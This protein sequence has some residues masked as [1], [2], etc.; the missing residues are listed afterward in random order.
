MGLGSGLGAFG[1]SLQGSFTNT[2]AAYNALQDAKYSQEQRKRETELQKSISALGNPDDPS[3]IDVSG[4]QGAIPL[5]DIAGIDP[6][7][8]KAG[9]WVDAPMP[10]ATAAPAAVLVPATAP[11]STVAPASALPTAPMATVPMATAPMATAPVPAAGQ[12]QSPQ[13]SRYFVYEGD[14]GALMAAANP[15]RL[16]P[17]A[18]TQ[19]VV[20]KLMTSGLP[21]YQALG[22]QMQQN[23]RQQ[24]AHDLSMASERLGQGVARAYMTAMTTGDIS[25]AMD[26]LS[27]VFNTESDVTGQNTVRYE[28]VADKPGMF[29]PT[30]YNA[31]GNLVYTRPPMSALDLFAEA[32]AST[33]PEGL[34]ALSQQKQQMERF[35]Q[36]FALQRDQF[37]LAQNADRRAAEDSESER[38][39]RESQAAYYTANAELDAA[40]ADIY[41]QMLSD[42]PEEAARGRAAFALL[43][44]KSNTA[45]GKPTVVPS[46]INPNL[47]MLSY[48]G[49]GQNPGYAALSDP[50]VLGGIELRPEYFYSVPDRLGALTRNVSDRIT[51]MAQGG[52]PMYGV[53]GTDVG[54]RNIQDVI[55]YIESNPEDAEK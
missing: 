18:R 4:I 23:L 44:G 48:P 46:P 33:S 54:S 40:Q 16:S 14:G 28:P 43:K 15:P 37:G 29:V 41:E 45:A 39:L 20:D 31:D 32:A 30:F 51:V 2:I 25:G 55:D 49:S 34:L 19:A 12:A 22:L 35:E 3:A 26:Q 52:V 5:S 13:P 21:Q 24:E 6:K 47:M 27:A 11:A 38:A 9:T 53:V 17:A 1:Q 10:A 50:T 42:D 7:S 36:E 8:V